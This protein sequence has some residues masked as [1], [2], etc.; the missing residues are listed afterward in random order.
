M[1]GITTSD[2]EYDLNIA[3]KGKTDDANITA[4]KP[5][6]NS[7]DSGLILKDKEIK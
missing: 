2:L 6:Q 7:F 1:L 3:K 5:N 4:S